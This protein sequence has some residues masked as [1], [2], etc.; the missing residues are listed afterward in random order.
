MR[1][2]L[3]LAASAALIYAASCA[4]A[5]DFEAAPDELPSASLSASQVA[6]DDFHVHDPVSNDGLMRH[7]IVES[8]FGT[9]SA[10]G[11]S[12]LTV[13][14]REVAAL[15][16]IARTSDADVVFRSVTR[17]LQEDV[18]SATKVATHPVGVVSGIPRGIGH[19]L[20]GYRAQA[21]ELSQQ[22][23]QVLHGSGDTKQDGTG[24]ASG[25][26][27]R[28]ASKAEHYAKT[29][30]ANAPA[31]DIW[32]AGSVSPRARAELE[33]LGWS[34]HEHSENPSSGQAFNAIARLTPQGAWR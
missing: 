4:A 19:L 13:R 3:P 21:Q 27:D 31:H 23:S 7:Y 9:F 22:A 26:G 33:R 29:Y 28:V 2:M 11:Q 6:G 30:A 24:G 8:R 14:L 10:Y 5:D 17:G 18:R 15:A 1:S 16:Q 20:G 25:T 12:E 34:V 32:F